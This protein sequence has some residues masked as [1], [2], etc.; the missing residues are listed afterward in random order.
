MAIDFEEFI[1]FPCENCLAC[2]TESSLRSSS[3]SGHW[4]ENS[5]RLS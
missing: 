2:I 3:E 4:Q 5:Y 1:Y